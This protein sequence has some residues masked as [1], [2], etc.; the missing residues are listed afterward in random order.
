MM[1]LTP[2]LLAARDAS[3]SSQPDWVSRCKGPGASAA[4]LV[5]STLRLLQPTTPDDSQ[6]LQLGYTLQVP[7]LALL[8]PVGNVWQ[9][10]EQV[11]DKVVRTILESP[12]PAVLYLFSTH[13][14][15]NAPIELELSRDPDN[16]SHTQQGPL[17]IDTYYSQPIYPWS[18]ARTDNPITQ[19]RVKVID[20]LVKKI[21]RLPQ[22]VRSRIRG[23]TLL[24]EVHQLFPK[25]ESGMGFGGAYQVSD[26]S[27]ASV[28]AFREHLQVRYANITELNVKVGSDYSSFMEII[29]PGKDIRRDP[30]RRYHE[31]M[32][33]YAAGQ[34]PITG[35]VYAP[36]SPVAQQ[37][38]RIYLNGL[39]IAAAPV[40]LSRQDV[41]SAHPEFN[42]ADLGWR[43]DLDFSHLAP[44]IH[45]IDLAL[46]QPGEPLAH[47]GTRTISIMDPVQSTPVPLPTTPLPAMTQQPSHITAYLDEPRDQAAYYFNPLA[48][49]WQVF[50]EKQVVDYLQYFNSFIGQSC[51]SDTPRYTHQ[52]VPQFNPGW[53]SGKYAVNAS[54]QPMK[55]LHTGVSLYGESSY[56]SSFSDWLGKSPRKHYGVTEFHPLQAMSAEQLGNVLAQHRDSGAQFVSFFLETRWQDQRVSSAPNLFSFDPQNPQHASDQLYR[57]LASLLADSGWRGPPH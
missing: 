13:F 9:V 38:V 11:I 42:T 50:R 34:I 19:Y 29:P 54:L 18:L 31:H 8:Q 24:G 46:S 35:W 22:D 20:A 28:A 23:I 40:R 52:I 14:S 44:G 12:R 7:L 49:E 30:L 37:S 55:T 56:G 16:L 43:H 26:Y 32:D 27:P 6:S 48:R 15:V 57:S 51:L 17:P 3:V 1:D 39:P 25:F 45:R 36:G 10:N 4:H 5:E 47:L 33:A 41:R 21:C 2:C 53:D